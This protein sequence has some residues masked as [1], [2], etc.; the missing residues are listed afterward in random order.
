MRDITSE[1]YID[2]HVCNVGESYGL[3]RIVLHMPNTSSIYMQRSNK[4]LESRKHRF[5]YDLACTAM[6]H[7][8]P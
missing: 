5:Y 7:W 2:I 6:H 8:L 1:L 4:L 3:D